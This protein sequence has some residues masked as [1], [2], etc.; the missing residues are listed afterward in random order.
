MSGPLKS[1]EID[2]GDPIVI[3]AQGMVSSLG[4]D[5]A[6]S[7]AAARAGLRRAQALD[8]LRVASLDG[9]SVQPAVGHAAPI[10]THGFEGA[11]RLARLAA[12][13]L[14]DVTSRSSL[15][16]GTRVGVYISMPSCGRRFTGADLIPDPVA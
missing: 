10:I 8:C 15:P 6:T 9:R 1:I 2:R 14:R 11:P 7:C 13:A 5:V 16:T 12:A 3:T 4:L